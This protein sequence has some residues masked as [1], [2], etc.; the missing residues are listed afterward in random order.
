MHL[1]HAADDPITDQE[2]WLRPD[3]LRD[4]VV[5]E[6]SELALRLSFIVTPAGRAVH[7][8]ISLAGAR[9]RHDAEEAGL[10]TSNWDRMALGGVEWRM[11]EPLQRWDLSVEDLEAGLR[12]YVSFT[13]TG[14]PTRL[15]DGY[16]QLGTV[17][18]QVRLADH[19]T[20][21]TNVLA[22]RAHL[23]HETP[24]RDAPPL[25]PGGPI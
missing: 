7:L 18:G 14:P 1:V 8:D 6:V 9:A 21:L 12:A 4:E 20:T 25:A 2:E 22:R 19:Q 13:G 3:A 10:P 17:S 16:E 11:V 5:L 15:P 24:R 23:W